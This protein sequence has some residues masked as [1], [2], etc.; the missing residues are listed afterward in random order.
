M[1]VGR[2][3]Q[4][5]SQAAL[6]VVEQAE[7][8]KDQYPELTYDAIAARLGLPVRRLRVWRSDYRREHVGG[9][10]GYLPL[11]YGGDGP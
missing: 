9:Q 10:D 7:R 5:L 8:L 11:F 6:A 1:K 3:S 2:P 4:R